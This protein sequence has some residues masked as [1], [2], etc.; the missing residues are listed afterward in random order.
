[1]NTKM[2]QLVLTIGTMLP[3]CTAIA[4]TVGGTLDVSASIGANCVF[5]VGNA[6]LPFGAL[7]V[8]DLALG[9]TELTP[10]A[11]RI[12]CTNSGTSATL[13]GAVTREMTSGVNVIAYEVYTDSGHTTA[14]GSSVGTGLTITANGLQQTLTLYGKTTAA[15]GTKPIGSYTQALALTV[16][17]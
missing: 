16:D 13:Y 17:F 11:V 9:K 7:T 8:S 4:V 14:L 6:T 1:M 2:S 3:C 5:A 15:Q 12:T 10:A